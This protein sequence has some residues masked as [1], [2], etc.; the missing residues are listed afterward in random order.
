MPGTPQAVPDADPRER[1]VRALRLSLLVNT[2]LAL[3]K[4]LVGAATGSRALIADGTHSLADV[5]TGGVAWL[6]F[7]WA[8]RPAYEAANPPTIG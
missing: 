3:M 2:A 4:L 8:S 1:G 5:A 6:S 7:H